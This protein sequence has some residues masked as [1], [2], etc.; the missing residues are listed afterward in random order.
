MKIGLKLPLFAST[1]LKREFTYSELRDITLQVEA[2]GFDSIWIMDHFLFRLDEEPTQGFCWEAWTLLSALAEATHRIELGSLVLCNQF[3]NPA[4][5]AKMAVTLDAVSNG[6]FILG[7]G[8]GWHKPEFDAIGLPFDHRVSRF[9]EAMKVITPLLKEGRVD[10]EG[11]YYQ[12]RNCE[13]LPRGPRLEGPQ[14]MIGGRKP[15]MLSLIAQYADMW[16]L[17]VSQPNMLDEPLADL[18][19]ACAK[20]GRDL[21]T[22]A[23]TVQV[24][25]AYPEIAPVPSW[26]AAGLSGS[27]DEIAV[28]MQQFDELG[29]SHMIIQIG[30]DSMPA[31]PQLTESMNLYRQKNN[32]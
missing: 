6:R 26:I 15:R 11:I 20:V 1:E 28:A 3:R 24:R 21:T 14:I 7:L 8:A 2:A 30:P 29:V 17:V 16:N 10:F 13:I 19:A 18:R 31:L 12:A 23:I 5:L 27:V 9:E 32:R 4:I 22:L 25:I